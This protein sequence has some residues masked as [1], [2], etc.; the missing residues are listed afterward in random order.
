M[1]CSN[2]GAFL[3]GHEKFCVK[4]GTRILAQKSEAGPQNADINNRNG[5]SGPGM[6]YYNEP[7]QNP[8][9]EQ[10]AQ[11]R[12]GQR[13]AAYSNMGENSGNNVG[14]QYASPYGNGSQGTPNYGNPGGNE[15]TAAY[16]NGPQGASDYGNPGGNEYTA[17]YGNGPQG[18]SNYGNPDGNEYTA[19]YGNGP[20]GT[21]NYS[22]QG[23]NTA[24][25]M[26]EYQPYDDMGTVKFGNDD[27]SIHT[28]DPNSIYPDPAPGPQI[29]NMPPNPYIHPNNPPED[30]NNSEPKRKIPLLIVGELVAIAAVGAVLIFL[31]INTGILSDVIG[32]GSTSTGKT[33][34]EDI[35]TVTPATPTPTPTPTPA[36]P[37]PTPVT[38]TPVT[39]TPTPVTPTPT[40]APPTAPPTSTPVTQVP[41]PV[42]TNP[43]VP[44]PP[45]VETISCYNGVQ[46]PAYEFV[47]PY[48]SQRY[49][50][51]DELDSLVG[52]PEYMHMQ[53][54]LAINEIFARYGYTFKKDTATA[55][56][57][58]NHFE[59]HDWYETLQ[60]MCPESNPDNLKN[61]YMN[62]YEQA[63]IKMLNDWQ[64][65]YD[66]YY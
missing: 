30:E 18:A 2:C 6:G 10:N 49:L 48:S 25:A 32:G 58:R 27:E 9:M 40:P 26:E 15:Y 42:P 65:A 47:F 53:S 13:S 11:S 60:S 38:P 63:N 45:S 34:S 3:N 37:T 8:G 36:T 24:P 7:G 59:G 22:N 66:V 28:S 62:A 50:T 46:A 14:N 54:Q 33:D 39:P 16:G 35:T 56:D 21:P 31:L 57:A 20:Q 23:R 29:P 41:T 55:Q 19:A 12:A 44:Q 1:I 43:P 17:A 4:C 64:K 5:A 52:D 51:Q 61:Y